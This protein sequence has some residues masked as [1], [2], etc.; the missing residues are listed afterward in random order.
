M[1]PELGLIE[2]Y[3]GLPWDWAARERVMRR[4]AGAG[5]RFFMYAPKADAFLRRR[6]RETPP[7]AE[8]RSLAAFAAA[9]R[10]AGVRFGVGLS[11]FEVW[12]DFGTE[13]KAALADK[14]AF[15]DNL[16]IEDLGV[17]FDDMRG[18][19]PG[20]A[21]AQVDIV[22]WIA[23]RTKATRVVFCPTY[24]TDDPALDMAFGVR[25]EGYLETLGAALD[26][27]IEVFWTGEEVCSRA[28]G[29]NHLARVTQQLGRRPFLWD[30]YPVNDGP[31]MSP[32][33][34]L[35]A[36]TGRPA[37]IGDHLAAHAVNPA[38]QP[39]LT[40]LPALT[41]P[42]SYRLGDAYDYGAALAA[43]AQAVL[44]P[45]L[46]V[47]VRRHLMLLNDTGRDRIDPETL[48]RLRKRYSGFDHPAA[49]EIVDWL[50]GRWV[51]TQDMMAGDH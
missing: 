27:R 48:A 20:L 16:G 46:A 32:F 36:F 34:Y 29:V 33:L 31:R 2:G 43:S 14:L 22:H 30:N 23:G 49:R 51:L 1:T 45:D 19:L 9:C 18:D 28:Y 50:D 25:P 40:L 15:L 24:Y 21:E 47:L 6:W 17:L 39:E 5:Y 8:T 26:R 38:L 13:T 11:P 7:E 35:R 42:E 37:A 4:L 41:L 3:Y 44:G 12:Q 10:D